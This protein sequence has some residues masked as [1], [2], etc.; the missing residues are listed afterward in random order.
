MKRLH[1]KLTYAN[2]MS[3]VAVF[4]VLAGGTAFAATEL[5]PNNS[6]GS[7][8]IKKEAVTPAKLSKA[9]KSTLTG[10]KGATGP[11]GPKGDTG[12]KG[13]RGETGPST[14]PA[15]GALA[16]N[17]PNPTLATKP[18][19]ATATSGNTTVL[20]TACTH[21][22]NAEVTVNAPSAG[23]VTVHAEA[24]MRFEHTTGA[25]DAVFVSIN[26]SPTTCN[27]SSPE[28]GVYTIPAAFPTFPLSEETLPT[29]RTFPVAA[30]SNTF[31]LNGFRAATAANV[32]EFWYAGLTATFIPS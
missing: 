10:P 19:V 32:L 11:Q 5:L 23:T 7:K 29:T 18:V 25:V 3:S 20:T 13:D 8:Q 31:Y 17:Y 16:G 24:T 1:R 12:P 15:G 2:V 6:V 30:G 22:L 14:G 9:A 21:Y 28:E 27:A 4:L 26:T